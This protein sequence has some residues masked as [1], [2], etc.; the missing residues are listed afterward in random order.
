M[1]EMAE[2]VAEPAAEAGQEHGDAQDVPNV[3][4]RDA[5]DGRPAL[6][7]APSIDFPV[8]KP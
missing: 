8:V 4:R 5:R 3:L 1:A 6:T 7:D 2:I